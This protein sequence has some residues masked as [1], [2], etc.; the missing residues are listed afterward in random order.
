M[1]SPLDQRIRVPLVKIA[2]LSICEA[3]H[4]CKHSLKQMDG[5]PYPVLQ[6]S[7]ACL[8]PCATFK[9]HISQKENFKCE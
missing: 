5:A 4:S 2:G 1:P 9:V 6:G 7:H 8:T 3:L